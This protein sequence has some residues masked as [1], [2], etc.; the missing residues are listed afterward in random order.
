MVFMA[1]LQTKSLTTT[2]LFALLIVQILSLSTAWF[3]GELVYQ[4]GLDVLSLPQT[5]SEEHNHHM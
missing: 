4:H 2:L 1:L 5:E 3:G